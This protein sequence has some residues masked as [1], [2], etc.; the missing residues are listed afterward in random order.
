MYAKREPRAVRACMRACVRA[1]VC[2]CVVWNVHRETAGRSYGQAPG[3][4]A[5]CHDW[6]GRMRASAEGKCCGLVQ[7]ASAEGKP[8]GLELGAITGVGG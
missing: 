6:G 8:C 2:V 3:A 1:C 5:E 4:S 7:R